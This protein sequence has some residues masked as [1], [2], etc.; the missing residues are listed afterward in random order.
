MPDGAALIVPTGA[1]FVGRIRRLRRHPAMRSFP[2]ALYRAY[3]SAICRPDKAFTPPSGDAFLPD[4]VALIVPTG[5]LFVGRIR[6]S[7]R[8]P[9]MRSFPMALRL[10]GLRVIFMPLAILQRRLANAFAEGA[11]KVRY[12]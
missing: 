7:R 1:L 8:Y 5:A 11:D 2:M 6:R 10:S 4:G 3:G 9:A 12:L